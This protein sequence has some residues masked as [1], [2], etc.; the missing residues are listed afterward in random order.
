MTEIG[1]NCRTTQKCLKSI[2]VFITQEMRNKMEISQLKEI[3][4]KLDIEYIEFEED[5]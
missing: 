5:R 4:D 1:T 3:L 2:Q